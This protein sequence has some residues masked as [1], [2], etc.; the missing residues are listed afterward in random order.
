M[1]VSQIVLNGSHE[2]SEAG[3]DAWDELIEFA[4]RFGR[5]PAFR[6][7]YD[8][9]EMDLE[10]GAVSVDDEGAIGAGTI[11]KTFADG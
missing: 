2:F 9:T 3:R 5:Q 10:V 11:L 8:W 7:S 6:Q 1:R 4:G